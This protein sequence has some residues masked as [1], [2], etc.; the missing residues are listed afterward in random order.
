MNEAKIKILENGNLRVSV[1]VAIRRSDKNNYII[2]PS[3][4][5]GSDPDMPR[6]ED[7]PL[8]RAIVDGHL[9]YRM[10]ESGSAKN[11]LEISQKV[12]VDR[13]QIGRLI[14]L[15][16]LAPDIITRIFEGNIPESLNLNKLKGFIPNS[17]ADQRKL[18]LN[19]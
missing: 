5:D 7:S 8:A 3:A 4:L 1:P 16:N 10:I 6:P 14:R 9:Y 19:E 2:T 17:W 13:S 11:A 15:V 12:G 18:L